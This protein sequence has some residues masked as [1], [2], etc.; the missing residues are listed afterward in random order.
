MAGT[1]RRDFLRRASLGAVAV[2]AAAAAPEVL[3]SGPAL[4]A[5]PAAAAPPAAKPVDGPIVVMLRDPAAGE[6]SVLNGTSESTFTDKSL[7]ARLTHKVA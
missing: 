6:F 5:T 4:A 7:A 2:G 3:F 1:N